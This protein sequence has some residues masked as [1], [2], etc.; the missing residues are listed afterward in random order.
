MPPTAL[1]LRF[2]SLPFIT[3]I[4]LEELLQL[5]ER[6]FAK[7]EIIS[8][9]KIGRKKIEQDKVKAKL[10]LLI[11]SYDYLRDLFISDAIRINLV[12][13]DDELSFSEAFRIKRKLMD[14]GMKINT[15]VINKSQNSRIPKEVKSQFQNQKKVLF[16]LSSKEL[17]GYKTLKEFANS[18]AGICLSN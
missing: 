9:I 2:F 4:W 1:T 11:Y 17:L 8:N 13:N 7:K 5:R 3:L 16:P 6:I 15:V 12:M 18:V 10:R 14:I